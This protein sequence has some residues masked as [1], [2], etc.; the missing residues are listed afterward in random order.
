MK[1]TNTSPNGFIYRVQHIP[2]VGSS[3]SFFVEC[4][5][6][7]EAVHLKNALCFYDLFQLKN[8]IKPDFCNWSTIQFWDNTL[9]QEEMEERELKDKWV[10]WYIDSHE[11]IEEYL[12]DQGVDMETLNYKS[13]Y[14][15]Y[16]SFY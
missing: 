3:P 7:E 13:I 6:I 4:A 15:L 10:D 11:D 8:K 5:T 16:N 9:T 2:Q 1:N 12:H 14:P